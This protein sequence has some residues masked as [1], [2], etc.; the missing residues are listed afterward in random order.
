MFD[1]SVVKS[2]VVVVL[3]IAEH[4]LYCYEMIAHES[5]CI[6]ALGGRGRAC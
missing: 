3:F 6:E 4:E 5:V 2:S 1:C